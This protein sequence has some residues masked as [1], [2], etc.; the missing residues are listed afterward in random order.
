MPFDGTI[1]RINLCINIITDQT[2]AAACAAYGAT[3]PMT[4]AAPRTNF[5]APRTKPFQLPPRRTTV[6]LRY[7]VPH[8]ALGLPIF[9]SYAVRRRLMA[10]RLQLP[11]KCR[12]TLWHPLFPRDDDLAICCFVVISLALHTTRHK[13]EIFTVNFNFNSHDETRSYICSLSFRK[14]QPRETSCATVFF[15]YILLCGIASSSDNG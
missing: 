6:P 10:S 13:R 3:F 15:V 14:E 8:R 4:F 2:N 11:R 1:S 12:L 5:F 9:R 7:P